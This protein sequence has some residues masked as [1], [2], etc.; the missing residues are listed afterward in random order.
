MATNW[1]DE[2]DTLVIGGGVI[3]CS[4]ASHLA[5]AGGTDILV[6]DRHD[7]ATETTARSAGLVSFAK[8]DRGTIRMIRRTIEAIAEIEDEFGDPVDFRTVGTMRAAFSE[9]CEQD[10]GRLR[11]ALLA[12]GLPAEWLTAPQAARLCPWLDLAGAR[13]ILFA[14]AA[15]YVDAPRLAGAY[16]RSARARGVR[17][18]RNVEVSGL[19]RDGQR[20]V[21]VDTAGGVI[22]ARTVIDAA[23]AW[24][25]QVA[26][27]A[28][29]AVGA[30]PTR[31]HYWLTG[32]DGD[33]TDRHPNLMLPDFRAYFRPE[34]GGLLV[35]VREARSKTF[36]P[37]AL[38]DTLDHVP[39]EDPEADAQIL[40]DGLAAI[41][42]LA[43]AVDRWR[44][45]HH[46]AGLS[47]YTPDGYQILGAFPA[48]AGFLVAT[49]CCGNG[50]AQS[51]GI[52][53]LVAELAAGTAP[54]V[55]PAPYRPERFADRDVADPAFRERAAASRGGKERVTPSGEE[56]SPVAPAGPASG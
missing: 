43:P 46:I 19:V 49:G 1:V 48:V 52:G 2:A 36:D 18:R 34:T 27:W 40:S 16:A 37:M 23:G 32:T 25:G 56:A 22:R 7:L 15:G 3:G 11:A 41:R 21:G 42:H 35:G 8:A 12:E 24:A 31:S 30:V 9:A 51:G 17:F 29:L 26:G 54:F 53:R 4:I 28:G 20:V 38:P 6:V 47:T 14:P 50:V 55:D 13:S 39:L 5:R 33:V 45:R 44:F 10:L